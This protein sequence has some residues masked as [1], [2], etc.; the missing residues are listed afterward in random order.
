IEPNQPAQGFTPEVLGTDDTKEN[1]PEINP[2]PSGE[3]LGTS[4]DDDG[5]NWWWLL[6]LIIP[7]S[8]I[9]YKFAKRKE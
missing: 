9:G 1:N 5:F 4:L 8:I 7:V 2:V 3:V 6:L